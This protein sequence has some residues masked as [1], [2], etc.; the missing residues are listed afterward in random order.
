M[1]TKHRLFIAFITSGI[2]LISQQITAQN[3]LELS[4]K[5]AVQYATEHNKLIQNA[6]LSVQESQA[7]YRAAIVQGLPQVEAKIDYQNYF[8]SQ[9]YLGP[10]TFTFNPTSNLNITVG[11]L[12]FS[13]SYIVGI[14][15]AN[16][17]KEITEI[18]YQK[19]DADIKA[20]VMNSYYLVL[21]SKQSLEILRQNVMNMEDVI[22]KTDALVKVGILDG[23]DAD[24]I[25]YQKKVLDNALLSAERQLELATNLLRMQLGV[26][27]L[28]EI[29]L[30][31]DLFALLVNTDV[32][33]SLSAQYDI[34]RNL[35]FQLMLLQKDIAKK[36]MNM[37]K[38]KFLP[39]ITGFYNY[40]EKIKKPELD[41]SPKN[42]IGFN[43]G[44]PIFSS[45]ARY[46]THT[47]A[48]IQYKSVLNQADFVADQLSIQEKQLRQN[49]KTA[50]EQYDA[51]RENIDLAR[52]V[53]NNT[54]IKYQQGIV[55]GLDLT[56]ANT[57]L[58][59]A[60]N[61]YLMMIMQLLDA[62][63]SLDKFLNQLN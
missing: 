44:I 34:N 33:K 41:F 9:A 47:Q 16:L 14:Q 12:I 24:Q 48:K 49:L 56:T 27:A 39:T 50:K 25:T 54:Y 61:G 58:L 40:T 26:N 8:N 7:A 46:F 43:I 32:G 10:M 55:S 13:G 4:L 36:K 60:E 45:G 22:L 37:E 62:K 57:N 35:D 59:Q 38:A 20:Q 31:D 18:S 15:M 21:I 2:L 1:N 5:A 52:K 51:Q 30:T 6:S 11:Q 42:I 29:Q 3:K 23:T 28:T 63:V 17:Y 53:Y 19:T